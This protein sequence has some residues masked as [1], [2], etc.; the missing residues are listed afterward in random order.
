MSHDVWAHGD[1][2]EL[3][4]GRWSRRVAAKFVSWL[5]VRGGRRWLDV[6]CG[7]GAL[8]ACVLT[9]ADPAEIVGIDPSQGFVQRAR[10][11][12]R[13]PRVR[14]QVG[15][16]R[17]LAF[18]DGQFD[19]VVSGLVLNFVPE[20]A[21]AVA[22]LARVTR[23][24]GTTAAFVW[25]YANG[26]EMLRHFWDAARELD[27][28]AAALDEGPRFPIC[29]PDSLQELWAGA[30]L[31]DVAVESITVPTPFGDFDDY[32][33]PFLGGQGP[34]PGYVMSLSAEHV[35]ALRESLLRRLPANSDRSIM[36]TARAWAVRGNR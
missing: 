4:M 2:Y 35:A 34:A 25:D 33:A 12:L 9:T 3:Y 1:P 19:A 15:D 10:H 14:F 27:P 36:L 8:T 30:G 26:M 29:R 11:H 23:P 17:S 32:W 31:V 5:G 6:G 18:A 24:G 16:A 13:D 22:E 7:T 21:A 20:T 28:A